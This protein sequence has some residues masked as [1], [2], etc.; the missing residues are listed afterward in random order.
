M[1]AAGHGGHGAGVRLGLFG[2]RQVE[3]RR[4]TPPTV[5]TTVDGWFATG[6]FDLYR[7]ELPYLAF[8][9]A[10]GELVRQVLTLPQADLDA[11]SVR[12][13]RGA[14]PRRPPRSPS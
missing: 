4:T 9:Q 11:L 8:I 7:R 13:T 1:L 2:H 5:A 3:A 6:K 12:L 10:A 14:A